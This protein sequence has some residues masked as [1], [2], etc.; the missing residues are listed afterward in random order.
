MGSGFELDLV[1]EALIRL[2]RKWKSILI[3]TRKRIKKIYFSEFEN[4][5]DQ[6]NN[7][8]MMNHQILWAPFFTS[9]MD[10]GTLLYSWPSLLNQG[11]NDQILLKTGPIWTQTGPNWSYGSGTLPDPFSRYS[12]PYSGIKYSQ[13]KRNYKKKQIIRFTSWMMTKNHGR[14]VLYSSEYKILW[15]QWDF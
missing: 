15:L 11:L 4:S 5:I 2:F 14:M 7:Q 12:S 10:H 6:F 13:K 8:I 1:M 3:K 9:S